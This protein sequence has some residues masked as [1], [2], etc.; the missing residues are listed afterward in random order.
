MMDSLV[1]RHHDKIAGVLSCW[2]RVVV[3]GTLPGICYAAGKTSFQPSAVSRR[4][5]S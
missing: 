1:D 2:D 5:E 4:A 3:Q